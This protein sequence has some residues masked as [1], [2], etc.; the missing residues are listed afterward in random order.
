[1]THTLSAPHFIP[2]RMC[3]TASE[4]QKNSLLW[5]AVETAARSAAAQAVA[6]LQEARVGH[7]SGPCDVNVNRDVLTAEGWWLGRNETGFSDKTVTVLRFEGLDGRPIALLFSHSVRP[8]ATERPFGAGDGGLVSADLAG[9][10]S[11]VVEQEL[12]H[13]TTA[14]FFMGAAGD[15]APSLGGAGGEDGFA[16][17]EMI[18]ARLGAEV[19]RLSEEAECRSDCGPIVIQAATVEFPGQQMTQTHDIQPTKEHMFAAGPARLESLQ[20]IGIGE[21]ALV[22]LRPELCCQTGVDIRERSPFTATLV[23]TM[24]N[25]GAKYMADLQAYDRITYEAMNSPFARGSAELMVESALALLRSV[26]ER[27]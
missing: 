15:Q 22:G 18:G 25:G 9:A 10:A 8:A 5:R 12:G 2:E 14:L 26:A 17:A 4:R 27:G 20:I 24:V 16:L 13:S 3:K 11:A 23:L 6:G 21:I 7:K 1:M 19:L